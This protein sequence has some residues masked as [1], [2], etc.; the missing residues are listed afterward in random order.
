[1]D[2]HLARLIGDYKASVHRATELMRQS[3]IALPASN[4][5]WAGNGIPQRGELLGG[6]S[7]FKHGYGCAVKLPE[8]SV[9]FDFGAHGEIDGFDAWRLVAF[10]GTRLSKYGFKNEAALITCFNEAVAAGSVV[11]SGYILHYVAANAV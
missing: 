4:T 6:I 10:A 1:M 5:D 9:D 3:D 7:Y 2:Q 11:Y 8:G